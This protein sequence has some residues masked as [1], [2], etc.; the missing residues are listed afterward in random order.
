MRYHFNFQ[1]DNLPDPTIRRI[2]MAALGNMKRWVRLMVLALLIVFAPIVMGAGGVQA[3]TPAEIEASIANGLTWLV[4]QQQAGGSWPGWYPVANTAAAVLK[5]EDRGKELYGSPFNPDYLYKVNVE[6]GLN[7]LFSQAHRSG[8]Q[9]WWDAGGWETTYHT[10]LGIMAIV[11]STTKDTVISGGP[12]DTLTYAQVVTYA[13]NFLLAN[14]NTDGGWIYNA[15]GTSDQ[16]N[17]GFAGLGLA[18]A[19]SWGNTL[20]DATK[21]GLKTWNTYIQCTTAG[22]TTYGGAGYTTPCDWVNAYKTGHLLY[23]MAVVGDG[24]GNPAVKL[25]IDYIANNWND[26]NNIGW[27]YYG[28]TPDMLASFM[29]MKGLV[30]QNIEKLNVGGDPNFDWFGDMST[31][32]VTTQQA[33][34]NWAATGWTDEYLTT[35]F[36]L[37]TLEKAIIKPVNSVYFDIKPGSCP[38]PI[39]LTSQGILPAAI[40]GTADFD[41]KKIDPATIKLFIEGVEEGV[42]PIRWSFEDVATPY[43]G[44]EAC[45][46]HELTADSFMDLALKFDSQEVVTTLKLAEVKGQTV[47]LVIR[48]NLTGDN[49]GQA[50]EGKDCVRVLDK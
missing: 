35:V 36:A 43:L 8:T 16:S 3:A 18:Y 34:G 2:K 13:L 30:G 24:A 41:V 49:G 4:A 46:C 19:V 5:L 44:Q 37:L 11:S 9:V 12:L 29:V 39:N 33:A 10:A 47:P 48:G 14:Q 28:G 15:G 50:F 23:N 38:N 40:A 45:G 32:I 1:A 17:T 31:V 7:Y 6:N 21:A 25:G 20:P 42:A 22:V 27:R 26:I